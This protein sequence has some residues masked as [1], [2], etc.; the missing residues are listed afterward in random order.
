MENNGEKP[1]IT[2]QTKYL[3]IKKNEKRDNY[4]S[5]FVSHF[6]Y[7]I[8]DPHHHFFHE[9]WS[10]FRDI[11]CS[12][13]VTYFL[14]TRK[15]SGFGLRYFQSLTLT[16]YFYKN[17]YRNVINLYFYERIF[18]NKSIHMVFEF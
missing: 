18:Q 9:K 5:S 13:L 17:I 15:E 12:S 3:I 8:C 16:S 14:R 10:I 4:T 2:H 7:G 6:V 11:S 1:C